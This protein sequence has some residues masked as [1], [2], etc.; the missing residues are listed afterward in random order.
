[1]TAEEY[2]NSVEAATRAPFGDL[3]DEDPPMPEYDD[4][5]LDG[6]DEAIE[7]EIAFEIEWEAERAISL[8]AL[9]DLEGEVGLHRRARW[10]AVVLEIATCA[11]KV[12]RMMLRGAS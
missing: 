4:R 2:L 9:A 8:E 5:L 6:A 7:R 12:R 10:V 3:H 1:M 11:L